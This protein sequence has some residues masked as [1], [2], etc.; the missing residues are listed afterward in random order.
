MSESVNDVIEA[1]AAELRYVKERLEEAGGGAWDRLLDWLM[2]DYFRLDI[3]GW[4]NI[5][6][7]G[8]AV[9]VANHSGAWGLDAFVLV[10]AL[11]RNLN[12]PLRIP[13]ASLTFRF[14]VIGSYARR[15]GAIP[16]DPTLGLEHLTAGELVGVFP[17]GTSGLEK[18]FRERYRLR[19]FSPG[20]AVT[21]V[22]AG[23]PVIP[24]SVI[25]AEEACPKVG[26][27]PALARLFD[28]PYFP[29]TT[30]FPLPSKWLITVGEPIPAPPRP[31]SFAARSA[32]AR[33]LCGEAQDAVQSLVD[34]ERRRRATPFW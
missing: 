6:T 29:L 12:R 30:L 20:F 19:P 1:G 17:E 10:K 5:P 15:V 33:R 31:E 24:V 7:E 22:Q 2:D 18:P 4:E 16:L 21:A 9:I 8:P 3:T 11:A 32:A 26:E 28:L 23:A 14:P 13:A 27:V 25:G 34:R